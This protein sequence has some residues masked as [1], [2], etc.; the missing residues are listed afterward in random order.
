MEENYF[1]LDTAI[2]LGLILT[3][4][5]TNSLKH[6][7]PNNREGKISISFTKNESKKN[8]FYYS[9]NGVG[10]QDGFDFRNQNTL[11]MKLIYSIG[12][13]QMQGK[14]LLENR[15][16]LYCAIEFPNN[17]Y[18][19]MDVKVGDKVLY[20]HSEY[21]ASELEVDGVK[22]YIVEERDVVGIL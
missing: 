19:P 3:E 15:S 16:G 18:K 6:A 9:D 14:V 22:H 13:G 8:V 1:L 10:L 11:G 17:L 21:G 7:F 20:N 5:M 12:E 4:L 2:P